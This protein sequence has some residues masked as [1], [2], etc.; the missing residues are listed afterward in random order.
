MKDNKNRNIVGKKILFVSYNFY[1][2]NIEIKNKLIELGAEVDMYEQVKYT[3]WYTL[4]LR[5]HLGSNYKKHLANTILK[6]AM[7]KKYDY[8]LVLEIHQ[9]DAFFKTLREL[10]SEACFVLYYWD[11][12]RYFDYRPFMK[13]F[14][15][16]YSFDIDDTQKYPDIH[17]QP[18]F[19]IDTYAKV[20]D[21]ITKVCNY[22]MLQVASF[23]IER[24]NNM[25]RFL[26]DYNID[27][28][29]VRIYYRAT[30]G[31]YILLKLKRYDMNWIGVKKLSHKDI[32]NLYSQTKCI[33]DFNKQKQSGLSMRT[34]ECMGAG[35]KLI[36][37]NQHVKKEPIYN[38]TNI[39]VIGDDDV[40]GLNA[41]I[42][43]DFE[44]TEIIENYSIRNFCLNLFQV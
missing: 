17:Y 19:F 30:L 14:D 28:R 26:S 12:I 32:A 6:A 11:S 23:Q 31:Q 5:L 43:K 18:L 39:F 38:S 41:F 35:K 9:T 15:R 24:Y 42:E 40:A 44:Y 36:T 21:K 33:L 13:Y 4:L 37:S 1:N 3:L 16:T 27:P 34:L 10:Q 22:D 8:V 7:K 2:Y 20:R 25:K 29:R